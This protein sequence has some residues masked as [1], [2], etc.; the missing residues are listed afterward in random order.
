M[1]AVSFGGDVNR[2]FAI[3]EESNIDLLTFLKV[4]KRF[5]GSGGRN[6]KRRSSIEI[7]DS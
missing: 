1:V 6:V 5:L 7:E 2:C 3:A 4:A